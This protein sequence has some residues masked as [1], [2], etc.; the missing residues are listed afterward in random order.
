MFDILPQILEILILK[1]EV[2]AEILPQW[3]V[4]FTGEIDFRDGLLLFII[5]PKLSLKLQL[6]ILVHEEHFLCNYQCCC[7][8][9]RLWN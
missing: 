3:S 1:M 4:L 8:W 2:F 6:N 7:D 5:F 9:V